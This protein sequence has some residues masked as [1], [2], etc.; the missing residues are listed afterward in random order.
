VPIDQRVDAAVDRSAS[1]RL[2]LRFGSKTIGPSRTS[3]S[4]HRATCPI[5][6]KP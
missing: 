5:A 2:T 1:S 3:F 4:A 6:Q